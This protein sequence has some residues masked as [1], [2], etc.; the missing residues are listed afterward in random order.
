MFLFLENLFLEMTKFENGYFV[1]N[2]KT[3]IEKVNR[4]SDNLISIEHTGK[5]N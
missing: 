4:I 1:S 3:I 5:N 2:V